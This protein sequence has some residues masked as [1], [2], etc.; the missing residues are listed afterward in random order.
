MLHSP[1]CQ[2]TSTAVV[3]PPGQAALK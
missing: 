1:M 3:T 2:P